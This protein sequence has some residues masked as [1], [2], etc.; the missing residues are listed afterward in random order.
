MITNINQIPVIMSI[1]PNMV[2]IKFETKSK[3]TTKTLKTKEFTHEFAAQYVR[4]HGSPTYAMQNMINEQHNVAFKS[5]Y[6]YFHTCPINRFT[7]ELT[8]AQVEKFATEMK[9]E[10]KDLVLLQLRPGFYYLSR[11]PNLIV[12]VTDI[13]TNKGGYEDDH[14]IQ[15]IP[16]EKA[17]TQRMLIYSQH[18][19]KDFKDVKVPEKLNMERTLRGLMM[20]NEDDI[21]GGYR[22]AVPRFHENG[23]GGTRYTQVIQNIV[24]DDNF[25]GVYTPRPRRNTDDET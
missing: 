5:L 18:P 17:P 20:G 23:T 2:E 21:W 11:V 14:M 13:K 25:W 6:D 7:A 24:P 3:A 10:Q 19:E 16:W 4:L 15:F 12:S 9:I 8:G 1:K 22:M